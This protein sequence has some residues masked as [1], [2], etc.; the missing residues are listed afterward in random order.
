[1]QKSLTIEVFTLGKKS[2][3]GRVLSTFIFVFF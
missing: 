2:H 1:V 3:F